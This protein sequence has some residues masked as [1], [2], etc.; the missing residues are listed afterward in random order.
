IPA[1]TLEQARSVLDK[2]K[3]Y[4]HPVQLND[5]AVAAARNRIVYAAGEGH[6]G[7]MDDI[8]ETLFKTM[9]DRMV[10]DAFTLSMTY[11]KPS[12]IYCPPPSKV[13]DSV[14]QNLGEGSLLFNYIG[15]GHPR[16]FDSLHWGDKRF[17]ILRTSDVKRLPADGDLAAQRPIAFLS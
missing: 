6:F 1:R 5:A 10:P 13:T 14:L 7:V 8:F 11:A 2:V 4:E 12:S 9:V 15:H 3:R 17:P 16:G